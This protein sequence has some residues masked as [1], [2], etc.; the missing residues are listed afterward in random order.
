MFYTHVDIPMTIAEHPLA[1]KLPKAT[2][3]ASIQAPA[4]DFREFA[5][6]ENAP[7][8]LA[9]FL[10]TDTP[11][12]SLHITSF[13][14]ATL[15]GLS[16]N[17]SIMDV[18]GQQAL[19]HA[20]SLVLAGRT[21]D[22]PPVLGARE[23]T[24][25]AL[26]NAAAAHG[27]KFAM[28]PHMLKGL[29]M[30]KFGARFAWGMLT[31]PAPQGRSIFLPAAALE[32]LKNQA[33]NDLKAGEGSDKAP[34]LSANDVLTAWVARAVAASLPRPRPI[35]VLHALNARFR[36]SSLLSAPGVYIQNMLIGAFTFFDPELLAGGLG[37]VALTNRS[38]LLEQAAEPQVLAFL[39]HLYQNSKGGSSDP[40]AVLYGPPNALL[41]PF[42]NWSRANL[43][44]TIDFS[45]AVVRPGESGP[46]RTN[47]P[48]TLVH[49]HAAS[50][51]I[52]AVV[53]NVVIVL[54]K[55][56]GGNYWLTGYLSPQAWEKI[57]ESLL[58]LKE[59]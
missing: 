34:V 9:D 15:V 57:E 3:D 17:H 41:L 11:N 38:L 30:A 19:V 47:P 48:G 1:S 2:T 43:Y 18:M 39:R 37:P 59:G 22:V 36:L 13:R 58:T 53:R 32:R 26:T 45:P 12:L 14:D 52:T 33:Q 35:T 31:E 54:G 49:H 20:W 7:A 50:M 44:E 51:N 42:T 21:V 28:E 23:D 5:A 27:E 16:W 10:A 29:G 55:D 25:Q 56:H 46:S 40:G 8:T 4:D 6:R 24:L